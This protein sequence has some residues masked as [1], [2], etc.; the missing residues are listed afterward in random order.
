[1]N[2]LMPETARIVR[3][4]KRAGDAVQRGDVLLEIETDKTVLEVE[5]D[6]DGTL[7]AV[8]VPEGPENVPAQTPVGRLRAG[9]EAAA[10]VAAPAP[11]MASAATAPSTDAPVTPPPAA[12][13][14]PTAASALM[15]GP[16]QRIIASPL[17]RRLARE[18][19]IDLAMLAGSGPG[20]R[21]VERDVKQA[22][23]QR[24]GTEPA[25]M[26]QAV[27]AASAALA[28]GDA[29]AVQQLFAPGSYEAEP[30]DG[31]RRTIALRL[32]EAKRTIPHFYL[33][34]QVR[35]DAVLRLRE[36]L[37]AAAPSDADGH[38]QYRLTLNDF[39][40]RALGL[41]LQRVPLANAAWAGEHIL[42]LR[43]SD[44][45][46]AIAIPGGLYTPVIRSVETKTVSAISNEVRALTQRARQR[47][48]RSE[49]C[50]GGTSAVSNLGMY[51]VQE[52]AAI[53]NPPHAT[54]LAV[55]R[56]EPCVVAQDGAP[57]VVQAMHVTLSCDHRVVDGALGAELLQAFT[58]LMQQPLNL[59]V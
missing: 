6:A 59:L 4:L 34:G 28:D 15:T 46:V 47:R 32:Q 50:Q 11:V 42:R 40:I 26:A 29:A 44:V 51:G 31:M 8:L 12:G 18:A 39:V 55:G 5:A 53:V 49:E 45:G 13:P 41:A 33:R 52:F 22:M 37:N 9:G 3:W 2:V 30:V 25:A 58:E 56:A 23:A 7:E 35:V 1:M 27:A 36:Q 21:I 10:P 43:T 16:R 19:G 20:G 38:P 48:L 57:A 17:A 14:A 24:H 54:M